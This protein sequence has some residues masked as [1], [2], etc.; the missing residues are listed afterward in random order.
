MLCQKRPPFSSH[1]LALLLRVTVGRTDGSAAYPLRQRNVSARHF[2]LNQK[3]TDG[4]HL[5]VLAGDPPTDCDQVKSFQD[6]FKFAQRDANIAAV[7][8]KEVLSKHRKALMLFG[9]FHLMHDQGNNTV[10]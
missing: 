4:K 7:M 10:V 3:L 1:L 2:I 6:I 8:E 5:R 9:T